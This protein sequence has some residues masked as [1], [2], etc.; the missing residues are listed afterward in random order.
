VPNYTNKKDINIT[1]CRLFYHSLYITLHC[2]ISCKKLLCP[3]PP[4]LVE[5]CSTNIVISMFLFVCLSRAYQ[6]SHIQTS[7]NFMFMLHGT[8]AWSYSGSV[9]I[10]YVL[11]VL[12]M[13]SC[14]PL[15][16]WATTAALLQCCPQANVPAA[17]WST[18]GSHQLVKS[19]K[20]WTCSY[21]LL[22]VNMTK[23][24]WCKFL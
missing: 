9:A 14:L 19:F 22:F 20:K 13:T 11:L 2:L 21:V 15:A 18:T 10:I 5:E 1:L 12:S 7:P 17:P 24:M 8:V 6:Q 4:P 3:P 23:F 16:V